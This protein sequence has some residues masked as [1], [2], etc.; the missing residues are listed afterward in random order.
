MKRFFFVSGLFLIAFLLTGLLS[1]CSSNKAPSAKSNIDPSKTLELPV[2]ETLASSATSLEALEDGGYN[3]S[4]VTVGNPPPEVTAALSAAAQRWQG[5]IA[6][7]LPDVNGTISAGDCGSNPAFSG[8]IDDVL[9][10]AGTADIDGP[11]NIL[12]QAGP[13]IARSDNGL[14]IAGVLIIDNADIGAFSSQLSEIVVHEMGH[15]LGIGTLWPNFNLLFGAGSR[16]PL[17][18]GYGAFNEYFALG[19]YSLPPVEN[20]GGSGTRDSHWRESVFG[21]ELMTSFLNTGIPN[22]LSR[23]TIASLGDLGYSVNFAAAEPYQL[24]GGGGPIFPFSKGKDI[25]L[26]EDILRPIARV[27]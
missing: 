14:T 16:N 26:N 24:P 11:N 12:A 23:L 3:I 9:I 5:V 21:N 18:A 25:R 7:G 1:A 17:F 6:D 8:T 10:F 22:P 27:K 20:E 19:G 15:I 4:L 2:Y 13:C